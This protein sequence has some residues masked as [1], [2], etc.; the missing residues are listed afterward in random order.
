MKDFSILEKKLN[1]K[2]KNKSLLTQAFCHRSYLNEHP[3]FS[4][5]HNERLEFLGDAVVELVV[6]EHLFNNYPKKREGILTSLRAALV[7]SQVLSGVAEELNF[8]N[9][10]LLSKGEEKNTKEKNKAYYDILAN[11]FEA[12]IGALYSD[13][14]YSACQTLLKRILLTKLPKIVKNNLYKDSKSELQEIA[15]EKEKIT[16]TYEILRERGPDH[17]R[18][19]ISGVYLGKKL[20]AKGEGSSKREAEEKAAEKALEAEGVEIN[21]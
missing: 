18:H 1:L 17:N 14:G 16:P 7:N 15:Q 20:I 4:V 13:Q 10:L 9:F 5:D 19:F 6:S 11:T 8:G 21:N 2:F 3:N 12:L